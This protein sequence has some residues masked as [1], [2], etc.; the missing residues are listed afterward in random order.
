MTPAERRF[1]PFVHLADVTD[2]AVLVGWGG[3]WLDCDDAGGCQVVDDEALDDPE[4]RRSGTIDV[5]S[6]SYGPALVEV[7]DG[8]GQVVASGE[9]TESNSAWVK[10]L[11]PDR[12]YRYRIV[13]DGSR[14]RRGPGG[15]GP[16]T[17]A[18]RAAG[19][20]RTTCTSAPTRRRAPRC[21]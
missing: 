18:T 10:G 17:A 4:R 2:T 21:R 6:T 15:T 9:A 11:E 16:R 14:G 8:D 1:E 12:Q 3:F 13:V 19:T 5:E 20:G 7:L